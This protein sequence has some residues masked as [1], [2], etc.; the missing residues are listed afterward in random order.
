MIESLDVCGV[1]GIDDFS[2]AT[3]ASYATNLTNISLRCLIDVGPKISDRAVAAVASASAER[4][5][6]VDLTWCGGVTDA[7][8]VNLAVKCPALTELSLSFCHRVG[9]S[10]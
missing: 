8:L 10:K 5:R 7:A 4:L 9:S 6:G 2:V 3:F 1:R